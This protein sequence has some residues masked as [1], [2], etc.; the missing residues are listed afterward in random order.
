MVESVREVEFERR[1]LAA[2]SRDSDGWIQA[3]AGASLD[4]RT[5]TTCLGFRCPIARYFA[6]A[7]NNYDNCPVIVDGELWRHRIGEAR[8][9]EPGSHATGSPGGE[10]TFEIH[11]SRRDG[12]VSVRNRPEVIS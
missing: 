9:I 3:V 8:R 4:V 10:I 6:V 1:S 5:T 11:L 12:E 2:P 7:E